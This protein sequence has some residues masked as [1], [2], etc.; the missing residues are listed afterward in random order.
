MKPL[1]SYKHR[2]W[3][4]CDLSSIKGVQGQRLFS[5]LQTFDAYVVASCTGGSLNFYLNF[6][7]RVEEIHLLDLTVL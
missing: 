2:V 3:L 4:H 6:C 1:A 7:V 5:S